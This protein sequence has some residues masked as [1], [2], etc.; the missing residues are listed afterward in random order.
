[1]QAA[2]GGSSRRCSGFFV[3]GQAVKGLLAAVANC[4]AGMLPQT[5]ML[6]LDAAQAFASYR[7]QAGAVTAPIH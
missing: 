2:R 1:M 3:P 4:R 6:A 5:E 7:P